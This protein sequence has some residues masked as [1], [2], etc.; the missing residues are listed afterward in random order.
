MF[1]PFS[2]EF[3]LKYKVSI[4]IDSFLTHFLGLY[5]VWFSCQHKS[6]LVHVHV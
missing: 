6:N 2:L 1:A 4:D 3:Y 5:P